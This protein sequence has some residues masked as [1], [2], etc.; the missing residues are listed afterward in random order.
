[1]T[2]AKKLT[3]TELDTLISQHNKGGAFAKQISATRTCWDSGIEILKTCGHMNV[4]KY[5]VTFEMMANEKIKQLQK[6]YPSLEWLAYLVGKVDHVKHTVL[7]EDLVIPD[8]QR[9]TGG[10]VYDVEYGWN[11][12]KS[13]IGVIHSH[14]SMGAFFSG[15]DDAYINQNHDVSIVVSTNQSSP[16]KGQVRMKTRCGAYVLAEDLSFSVNYP[17][18]LNDG[19]FE[20]EFTSKIK[21]YQNRAPIGNTGIIGRVIKTGANLL[22]NPRLPEKI[23]IYTALEEKYYRQELAKYYGLADID[24]IISD[25]DAEEEIKKMESIDTR[26]AEDTLPLDMVEDLTDLSQ[27]VM[28]D[29]EWEDIENDGNKENQLYVWLKENYPELLVDCEEH[30]IS[31]PEQ[32]LTDACDL[33]DSVVYN[34]WCDGND[35]DSGDGDTNSQSGLDQVSFGTPTNTDRV[36]IFKDG[37]YSPVEESQITTETVYTIKAGL[38]VERD[39][40]V[41]DLEEEDVVDEPI[42]Q[43]LH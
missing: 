14:H 10:N 42:K 30:I 39:D 37:Y 33:L 8:S 36:Y 11:E 26:G 40:K 43:V 3:Q 20:K 6:Y 13:I 15:T 25:G 19:N 7:V 21:S 29:D 24:E 41:W 23:V 12:G 27:F 5:S 34:D 4:P 1:M 2:G 17:K 38:Y 35:G 28:T 32:R 16:I 18:T 31:H 9:V 22:N